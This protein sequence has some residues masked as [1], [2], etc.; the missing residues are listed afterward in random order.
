MMNQLEILSQQFK[1]AFFFIVIMGLYFNTSIPHQT[2]N[3]HI[4]ALIVVFAIIYIILEINTIKK[5][6]SSLKE[7]VKE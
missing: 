3:I 1:Y 4:L 2:K 7:K 5:E 6:L